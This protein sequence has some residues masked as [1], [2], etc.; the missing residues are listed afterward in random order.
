[1][2]AAVAVSQNPE[3][4]LSGLQLK[5]MPD[6]EPPAGWTTVSVKASS[7]NMHDVWT[8][9]GV[10]HSPENI[11]MILGCDVAGV[12]EEGREV[13]VHP[14]IADPDGGRGDETLDPGRS[15]LSEKHHGGFAER[16]AV[17]RRCL[18]EKP[19]HLSFEEAACLPVAWGTAY[20]ML[21]TQARLRPGDSVLVQGAG[22][23]VTS[24]AITMARAAGVTV[25]ATSRTAE[26]RELARRLGAHEVFTAGSRLPH[27]VDAVIETVGEATWSHSLRCL[28]PG[29]CIV[30]AG[31]TTGAEPDAELGRIFF[32]QLRILGSTGSTRA[33]TEAMSRLVHAQQLRPRIDRVIALENIHEGFASMIDGT[34]SG[35]IV[36]QV[37]S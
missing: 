10:G 9:R 29:G 1:M 20:R 5:D 21:F 12:T 35:K 15:L 31:A 26:K 30:V 24:A 37:A 11:P 23:G 14:V 32:Q 19:A 17:P 4:P 7:L 33:E 3:D 28:R 6:P 2:R 22:G 27:R 34:V 36:V 25:Y 8:L 18:V 13:I 16:I